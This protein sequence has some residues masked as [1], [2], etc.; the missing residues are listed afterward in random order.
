MMLLEKEIVGNYR[1]YL[2]WRRSCLGDRVISIAATV[3]TE[4]PNH[5]IEISNY[6]P[7]FLG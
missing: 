1:G 7:S 5:Q 4:N 3:K 6:H 2:R